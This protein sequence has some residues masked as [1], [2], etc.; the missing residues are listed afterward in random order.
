MAEK[1]K[2]KPKVK[3]LKQTN[4]KTTIKKEDSFSKTP[5]IRKMKIAANLSSV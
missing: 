2:C 3:I 4:K 1:R 5:E